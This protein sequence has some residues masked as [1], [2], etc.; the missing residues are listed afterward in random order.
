M[1]QLPRIVAITCLSVSLS[2]CAIQTYP[3]VARPED[4]VRHFQLMMPDSL[5]VVSVDYDIVIW[6]DAKENPAGRGFVKVV[7]RNRATSAFVLML[8]EDIANRTEPIQ[9]IEVN[10]ANIMRSSGGR[11]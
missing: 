7:A 11:K 4:P 6:E 2:A 9:T 1:R 8:Y 3:E 10:S 5:E